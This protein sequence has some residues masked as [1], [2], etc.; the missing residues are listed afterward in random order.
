MRILAPFG[1]LG[2][3]LLLALAGCNRSGKPIM[4]VLPDGYRGEFRIVKDS[5]HGRELVQHNDWWVFDIPE[6]GTLYV[7]DDWPFYRWHGF[8]VRYRNGRTASTA[9]RGTT[10]G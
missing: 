3:V 2:L 6:D 1:L 9:E 8:T 10:P 7:K 4:I 5:E